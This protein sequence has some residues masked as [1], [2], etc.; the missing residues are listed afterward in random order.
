[1]LDPNQ[2]SLLTSLLTPPPGMVFDQ[3]LATTFT[4][5]PLTLLGIPLHL[6]WLSSPEGS[7]TLAD[8][9]CLL[10][11]LQRVTKRL[12][13]FSD[14]GRIH[15]PGQA[16]ALFALLEDTIVEVRAPRGG[17]FHPKLWLLRFVDG[18]GAADVVL[19]LGVLSRNL[20]ND[21]S[22][23]LSL[24]LEGSPRGSY[25]AAN[26]EL[27]QLIA[28]LPSWSVRE[29]PSTRRELATQLADEFRRTAWEA[30]GRWD[31]VSFHVLGAKRARFDPGGGDELAVISPFLTPGALALLRRGARRPMVLISRADSL[32]RLP[33][34]A[35]AAFDRC[36]VL[37]DAAETEDG[38]A[39]ENLDTLGLH[40][41]AVV[42]RRG[43]Y[44]HLFVGSANATSAAMV[45]ARNIEVMVELVGRHSQVGRIEQLLAPEGFGG[46]LTDFDPQTELDPEDEA[47]AETERRL[48]RLQLQLAEANLWVRCSPAADG[49]WA[50]ALE[51]RTTVTI[52]EASV[53]GW[54]LSLQPERGVDLQSL[55]GA[56][57]ILLATVDPA[58]ITGLVGFELRLN[59]VTRRFALNLEVLGLPGDRDAAILRR[60]VR[61]R[62]GFLRYLRL[63]LGGIGG[64]V[65]GGDDHGEAGGS[66]WRFSGSGGTEALLD[67]LV[68]VWSREP[69]RL[70][71]V[72]RV[73]ERLRG[74]EGE[75]G[76][77]VPPD[78][79]A[80]WMV[81]EQALGEAP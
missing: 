55:E 13:V 79:D 8:P 24:V 30:P 1:M 22:W 67:D 78:F 28:G 56:S 32:A 52:G 6:A 80:L 29:V 31:G 20:T 7:P 70:R 4:L 25:I 48:E 23:D 16:N 19:R 74:Y 38:E 26:R 3:G 39:P 12:T 43:W 18:G 68:R 42:L 77:I 37:D 57:S 17:A 15:V 47:R 40:A 35:R 5:D 51:T 69:A 71:D 54:P 76:A 49:T 53:A 27:G 36:L 21:R 50:L 75:D 41:K 61:N 58:D 46:V 59:D 34:D 62:E 72:Q 60:V 33:A 65:P 14:R 45:D 44:V 81:F 64:G 11:A 63:L 73:V 10:E 9:I 2:R 66:P